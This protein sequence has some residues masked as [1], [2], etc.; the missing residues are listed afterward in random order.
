MKGQLE[1]QRVGPRSSRAIA[2]AF[3]A[4]RSACPH[5]RGT[6]VGPNFALDHPTPN[7]VPNFALDPSPT[8]VPPPNFYKVDSEHGDSFR[9]KGFLGIIV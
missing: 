8:K 5:R 4:L 7:F 3:S 9:R 2:R 6:G 1:D